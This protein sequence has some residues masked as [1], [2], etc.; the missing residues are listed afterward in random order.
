MPTGR[1]EARPGR[2]SGRGM[3]V[4]TELHDGY[5]VLTISRPE[6]LNALNPAVLDELERAWA[7]LEDDQRVRVVVL[8]GAGDRAFVA[9]ADI[10]AISQ[11]GSAAEGERFARRGQAVLD[12][13]AQSR[14]V[15]IAAINGYA[16]GGGLELAMACD[17]RIAADSAEV[18]QP[19]ILLGVIP[20]FGGTQRL[21][22]LAGPG[23]A[24]WWILTGERVTATEA[25]RLGVIDRVVPRAELMEAALSL[26][27]K[28]A[29]RAPIALALA[30]RAVRE[31]LR[32]DLPT[33]LDLEAALFGLT[34]ATADARE[35]TRAFL[36]K[37]A[38][39]FQGA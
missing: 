1:K 31:G 9:G 14:L 19:E 15:S 20:G 5:A 27:R 8:T 36:E 30:K 2:P 18:G 32:G 6:A 11:I 28:L 3:Q 37:R 33:G 16:L 26:A 24:L 12:R 4:L 35:G 7:A 29:E 38:P 39:R 22:R 23:A 21:A 34:A 10:A 13:I 17:L 25:W